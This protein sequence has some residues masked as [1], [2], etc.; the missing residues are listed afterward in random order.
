MLLIFV[1]M[2]MNRCRCLRE[3]S[4]SLLCYYFL[5]LW[6]FY[7]NSFWSFW[8]STYIALSK[9]KLR[10]LE[11]HFTIDLFLLFFTALFGYVWIIICTWASAHAFRF[12]NPSCI[13]V[14]LAKNSRFRIS[15]YLFLDWLS[16]ILNFIIFQIH[17]ELIIEAC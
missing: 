15:M 10:Q 8:L 12:Y 14:S 6:Y 1:I 9:A 11:F 16:R 5:E 3:Y 17:Q 2:V 7:I 4:W 13:I